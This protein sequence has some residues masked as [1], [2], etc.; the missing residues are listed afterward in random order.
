MVL[1]RTMRQRD[2]DWAAE[3]EAA[4]FSRPWSAAEFQRDLDD[5]HKLTMVALLDGQPVGFAQALLIANEADIAQIC[6]DESM[7]RQGIA[8][9]LMEQVLSA[10]RDRGVSR[11]FLEVRESNTAAQKLYEN[12]SFARTGRRQSYYEQPEEDAILMAL[13]PE[14][15][16]LMNA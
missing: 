6:V 1:I 7:R 5:E 2:L 13:L 4:V 3:L 15:G 16:N 9:A 11:F 10:C 12:F 14:P 8:T